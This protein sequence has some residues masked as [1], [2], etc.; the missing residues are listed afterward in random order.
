MNE[1]SVF[2]G[3]EVTMHK[4]AIHYEGIEHRDIHNMYGFY[5]HM[6]TFQGLLK[7]NAEKNERPFLLTRSFFSGS[8]RYG[9][10]WTG[11]NAAQWSHLAISQPM[12]LSL[13]LCGIAFSGA[14][15]SGFFGNP[16]GELTTRWYQAASFQPFFRGH[17]HLDAKRK[18]PWLFDEP[19]TSHIRNAIRTRYN[20]LPY[21]YTT[22]RNSSITGIPIMRPLWV[23]FPNDISTFSI[24]DQFLAG[25]NILVKPVVNS[26]QFSTE[27]YLP[28]D[29]PWYEYPTSTIY[30]APQTITIPTP[31]EKIPI[32]LRGG[33]IIPKKDRAR[34]SSD[35]MSNDP[36][37]LIVS[38]DNKGEAFGELYIDDGHSYN[39]IKNNAFLER[40]FHFFQ[41][42]LTSTGST[43]NSFQV[44]NMIER[45]VINGFP[46]KPSSILLKNGQTQELEFEYESSS[47][48]LVI[49]KPGFP[50]ASLSFTPPCVSFET[51]PHILFFH[52]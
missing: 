51:A 26:K 9:A 36:Y 48:V 21:W 40:K 19:Y 52:L 30:Q 27:V 38:L 50:N 29:Q 46:Q 3:P 12:L 16:D 45:I 7:R 39:Y 28:G 11:D 23:E 33:S 47:S 25:Q 4:D 22:F 1:P 43:S 41:R 49:R 35:L 13:G 14:D 32:F 10:V 15:V 6:A 18:E 42:K 17:A 37:T 31:L 24:Q 5:M 8:Q 34:R 20:F 2:N 44:N